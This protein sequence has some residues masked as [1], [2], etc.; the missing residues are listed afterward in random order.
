MNKSVSVLITWDVDPASEV[1]R[2]NMSEAL[3]RTRGFLSDYQIPST[4][5]CPAVMAKQFGKDIS[6][7]IE[8]GHEI[9]CHGLTHGDEEDYS[10]M[11]KDVQREYLCEATDILK[12]ATGEAICSFRGPHV[13]TS[14][15]TQRILA[16]LE[17]TADCSVASQRIDCVSSN[18]INVHWIVAPRLPYRPSGRSAFRKGSENIWV[19]PLSALVLPFISSVLYALKIRVMKSLFRILYWESRRTGKP[20]VYLA[21]PYEFAPYTGVWKPQ[22]LSTLQRIRT[23]GCLIRE[24]FYESDHRQRFRMN[25]ELVCYMKSFPHIHFTTVRDYTS[26]LLMSQ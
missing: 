25:E 12:Q 13:K 9:G 6:N 5:F 1:S 26:Q 11:A 16:E 14:A 8:D 22:G 23:H 10:R 2:E 24:R 7:F 21:H 3:R 4:L 20:I 18:L 15:V 19:I 17:Y